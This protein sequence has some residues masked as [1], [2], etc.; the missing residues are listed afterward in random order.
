MESSSLDPPRT[1]VPGPSEGPTPP[2][3]NS[4]EDAD[5]SKT[6]KRPRLDSGDR[7]YR[8][9]SAEP[10]STTV[11]DMAGSEREHFSP[12]KSEEI[13]GSDSTPQDGLGGTTVQQLDGTPSKVT[14]NVR[15]QNIAS[16]PTRSVTLEADSARYEITENSPVQNPVMSSDKYGSSP[17]QLNAPSPSVMGSPEIEV[18]EPEDID[19][20]AGP[21]V[22]MRPRKSFLDLEDF[23]ESLLN[24]FPL[25][26]ESL[27]VQ[28]CFQKLGE[29]LI[30][31]E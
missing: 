29:I 14:I 4:M 5:S 10:S 16:S 3:R 13:Q 21:T 12:T 15:D 8:S 28:T 30:H 25:M 24:R 17:P 26:D 18:A 6:R 9:M 2:P 23:Q 1:P 7:A 19:G 31:G 27:T 20:H 11:A 22:W